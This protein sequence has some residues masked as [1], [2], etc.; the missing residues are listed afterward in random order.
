MEDLLSCGLRENLQAVTSIADTAAEEMAL[1]QGL[2]AMEAAWSMVRVP[3]E[4]PSADARGPAAMV[5]LGSP[6]AIQ[7]CSTPAV[8]HAAP[9]LPTCRLARI[10]TSARNKSG[11]GAS[12]V[13]HIV[14][15]HVQAL[16][17]LASRA[18]CADAAKPL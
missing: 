18:G 2:A 15:W 9:G 14:S 17:C 3:I 6:D 8:Q 4:P 11:G 12:I 16:H 7:V 5:C 13:Q 10:Y 1:E